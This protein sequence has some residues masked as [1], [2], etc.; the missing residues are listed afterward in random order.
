MKKLLSISAILLAA[1]LVFTGCSNPSSG[2]GSDP[3]ALPGKWKTNLDFFTGTNDCKYCGGTIT[4]D[5]KG[6]VVY[7]NPNPTEPDPSSPMEEGHMTSAFYT[8]CADTNLTGF[9][10]TAKSTSPYCTYG[11]GWAISENDWNNMYELSFEYNG[12]ILYEE[13]NGVWTPIQNW[14]NDSSIKKEPGENTVIVY[15][16][17]SNIIIKVNGS[18]IYTIKNAKITKGRLAFRTAIGYEDVQTGEGYTITY[19]VKQ[20]QY[21]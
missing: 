1:A 6:G 19:K 7:S 11:F 17:G 10:A 15:K 16:D 13:I 5:G 3:D 20:A 4:H 8:I 2:S 9:E 14:K 18:V 12:F 21:E